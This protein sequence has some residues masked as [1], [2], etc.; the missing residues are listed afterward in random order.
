MVT[1]MKTQLYSELFEQSAFPVFLLS[2]FGHVRYKNAAANKYLPML[3]KN[4]SAIRHFSPAEMPEKSCVLR[5]EG[6]T[7]YHTGIALIDDGDILVLCFS[8]F[9]YED[10]AKTAKLFLEHF[11]DTAFGFICK[12]HKEL[13]SDIRKIAPARN[14]NR[15]YTDTI[16][17]RNGNDLPVQSVSYNFYTVAE[18]LFRKLNV[19]FSAL[20]YRIST[21]ISENFPKYTEICFSLNDFLFLFGKLLYLQMRLAEKGEVSVTLTSMPDIHL[22]RFL[23]RTNI[24]PSE[25]IA[26][27]FTEYVPECAT[28]LMLLKQTGLLD[29]NNIRLEQNAFGQLMTEYRIPCREKTCHM[30]RSTDISE[31]SLTEDILTMIKRIE[32]RLKDNDAFY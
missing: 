26:A 10:G 2:S 23:I 28:E 29:H 30:L 17:A 4:A 32:D 25:D 19:S 21:Q 9:Q 11:G 5:I 12:M 16:F 14:Q 3:R 13:Y 8:R 20:G 18:L 1:V 15:I 7:P 6:N 27:L 31:L 22:L 24:Q